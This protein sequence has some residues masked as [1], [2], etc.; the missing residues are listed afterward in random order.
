MSDGRNI[1][2]PRNQRG[3][4]MPL[5]VIGLIILAIGMYTT[6]NLSRAVYEKIQL[7]NAA[8]AAAYSLATLEART[9][10]FMA[11]T[12]RAQIAN[13]VQMMEAQSILSSAMQVEMTLGILTTFSKPA[14][15]LPWFRPTWNILNNAYQTAKKV[16]DQIITLVPL[17]ISRLT[18]KNKLLFGVA[19][20]HLLAT[21]MLLA[22]GGSAIAEANDPDAIPPPLAVQGLLTLLNI[23]SF[24]TTIDT[25]SMLGIGGNKGEKSVEAERLITELA[26]ASRYSA[27]RDPAFVIMRGPGEYLMGVLDLV[28]A[29]VSSGNKPFLKSFRRLLATIL[30]SAFTGTTKLLQNAEGDDLPDRADTGSANAEH[31]DLA[32]AQAVTAKDEFAVWLK[33]SASSAAR[34]GEYCRYTSGL[35]PKCT[36]QSSYAWKSALLGEGGLAPYFLFKA[37]ESGWEAESSSF[38]QPDVWML[39]QKRPEAMALA[40]GDLNFEFKQKNTTAGVDARIGE[41]GMLEMGVGR[42][43]MAVARAQV[44]YHRP[45]AWQEPPNFFNPFWGARLAPKN[46]AIKRFAKALGLG[47]IFPQL[48]ADNIWMH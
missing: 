3:Q 34:T 8:D 28:N 15:V 46:V 39:F 9:F 23:G 25:S 31:S 32:R 43:M 16:V 11:F 24:V 7:Q 13:Y 44:Y 41:D 5:A 48:A 21:T 37:K 4:A 30:G 42:G 27:M 33:V 18:L 10:N 35:A 2:S 29:Q 17:E 36:R 1:M 26:N 6:Y 12:N 20:M 14:A 38:N 47:G 45:G 22:D 40:G 19:G